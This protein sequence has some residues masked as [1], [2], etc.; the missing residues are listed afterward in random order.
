MNGCFWSFC[1]KQSFWSNFEVSEFM[2]RKV[3]ELQPFSDL[4]IKM[5]L[6]WYTSSVIRQK[7]ESRN[8]CSANQG[9][10]IVRLLKTLAGFVFLKHPFWDSPFYLIT[11]DF[12][13]LSQLWKELL[14]FIHTFFCTALKFSTD[15]FTNQKNGCQT[16]DLDKNKSTSKLPFAWW[17]LTMEILE[18]GAKNVQS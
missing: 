1:S 4:I 3:T 11:D 2:W 10:R 16:Q 6:F 8:E 12:T 15:F 17:K 13:W 5:W 7:G 14:L 18:H 9:V